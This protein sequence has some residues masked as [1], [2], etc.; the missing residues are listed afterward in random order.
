MTV[1]L[2]FGIITKLTG[3]IEMYKFTPHFN[4]KN[5]IKFNKENNTVSFYS[6]NRYEKCEFTVS[7]EDFYK[8][9]HELEGLIQNCANVFDEITKI[10]LSTESKEPLDKKIN[11]GI[12]RYCG[13]F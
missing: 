12:Y 10:E 11:D 8:F 3:V 4:F 7:I 2:S 9:T 6:N 1:T 13:E 5:H